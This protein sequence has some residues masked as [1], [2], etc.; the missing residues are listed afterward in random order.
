MPPTP[1]EDPTYLEAVYAALFALVQTATFPAGVAINSFQRTMTPPDNVSVA[2][3]PALYQIPG[4]ML[5][6]QK[7]EMPIPKWTL[8]AI[9]AIYVRADS[10][11]SGQNSIASDD[12]ELHH[13]G[14]RKCDCEYEAAANEAN[15]WRIGLSHMA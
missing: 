6:E 14:H 9:L 3:M 12:C 2:N 1:Y 5:V 7:V 11:A 15:A 13:L 10:A 4:P 8:T